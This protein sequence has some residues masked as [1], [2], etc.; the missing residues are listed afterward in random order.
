VDP[1]TVRQTTG[2]MNDLLATYANYTPQHRPQTTTDAAGQATTVT[3]NAAG[4]PLTVTNAKSETTTS[5]YDLDG[6]C[7]ARPGR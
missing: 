3:H 1:L 5:M 4:Q 7:S 2:R 6:G